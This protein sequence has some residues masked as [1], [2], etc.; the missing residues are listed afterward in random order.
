[1]PSHDLQHSLTTRIWRYLYD[2][3]HRA[4]KVVEIAKHFDMDV[5]LAG[6]R[7]SQVRAQRKGVFR[8]APG[9]YQ[10]SAKP[11]S[12]FEGTMMTNIRE[13]LEQGPASAQELAREFKTS[14]RAVKNHITNIRNAG[15]KIHAAYD[16][17][18][19]MKETADV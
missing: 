1:M 8:V 2:N 6:T 4:I 13:R 11:M 18:Y 19:T 5:A 14:V 10:Y 7:M 17:T 9:T 12:E 16:V 15:Y 3:Q